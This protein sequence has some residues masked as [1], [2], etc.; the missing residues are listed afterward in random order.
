M[1]WGVACWVGGGIAIFISYGEPDVTWGKLIGVSLLVVMLGFVFFYSGR[2]IWKGGKPDQRPAPGGAADPGPT[3]SGAARPGVTRFSTTFSG[4]RFSGTVHT[5][6]VQTISDPELEKELNELFEDMNNLFDKTFH[7]P[8]FM[9][10][11]RQVP[12]NASPMPG[13]GNASEAPVT[14]VTVTCPGCGA[15]VEV[16][17]SSPGECEYCGGKV[18]YHPRG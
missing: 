13:A 15:P 8:G 12:F 7:Q 5:S 6:T 3:A 11:E 1:Y 4:P 9:N 2:W 14:P 10:Q 18:P 17:P 16:A